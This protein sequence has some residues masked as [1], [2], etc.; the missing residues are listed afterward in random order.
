MAGRADRSPCCIEAFAY[1]I[2]RND[3]LRDTAVFGL[4]VV[5]I[6]AG[7]LTGRRGTVTFGAASLI[8]VI[9]LGVMEITGGWYNKFSAFNT[10][11]DYVAVC[12]ALILVTALQWAVITRLKENIRKAQAEVDER[13]RAEEALRISEARY[14]L[15]VEEAPLGIAIFNTKR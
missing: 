11:A 8:V 4:V 12:V 10:T 1:L 3:G 7:L 13:R 6:S 2:F 9:T 5:I 14:R 15:L